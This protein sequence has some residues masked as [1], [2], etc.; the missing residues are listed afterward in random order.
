MSILKE[1]ANAL[2]KEVR[3]NID[4]IDEKTINKI[5]DVIRNADRV[6]VV[7]VGRSFVVARD[8]A[9]RLV[10]LG[11]NVSLAGEEVSDVYLPIRG[12]R[13]VVFAISGSGE[14]EEVID[15]CSIAHERGATVI[16]VTSYPDSTLGKLA[17]Y[18]VEVKGRVK[19]RASPPMKEFPDYMS[20]EPID[21]ISLR[22]AL[23]EVSAMVILEGLAAEIA[24]RVRK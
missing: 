18:I 12:E 17:D 20:G 13:D 24:A 19:P 10:Q 11:I 7:G 6:I 1:F 16:A 8:F 14:T 5:V 22:G 4:R 9:I 23:F 3:K 2:L 15:V 21:T